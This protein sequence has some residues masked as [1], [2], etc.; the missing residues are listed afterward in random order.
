ATRTG[1][2][3]FNYGGGGGIAMVAGNQFLLVKNTTISGN[4]ADMNGGG[5]MFR[6]GG[7]L[8]L[9]NSTVTGNSTLATITFYDYNGNPHD[10]SGYFGG[11]GLF[12]AGVASN[13]PPNGFTPGANVIVNSTITGNNSTGS[14]GAIF[15]NG[16]GGNVLIQDSTITGNSAAAGG[17]N[18]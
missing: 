17:E 15:G 12:L 18:G 1:G 6:Y 10:V 3:Y 8:E 14:G 13:S 4:S 11:A 5:I 2:S 7:T 9:E 16:L